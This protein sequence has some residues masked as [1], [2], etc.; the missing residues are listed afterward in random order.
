MND[1]KFQKFVLNDFLLV[2]LWKCANKYYEMRNLFLVLVL[3][4]RKRR[5]S[6]IKPQLKVKKE[7]ERDVP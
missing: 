1:L 7:D 2:K 5:F 6:Q 3:Y 4:C